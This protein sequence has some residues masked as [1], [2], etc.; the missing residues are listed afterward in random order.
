MRERDI[1]A[2]VCAHARGR[3]WSAIKL[4]GPGDRGKP[5]RIFIAPGGRVKFVEFKAPGK[6]PTALQARWL[7]VLKELGFESHCIDNIDIGRALFD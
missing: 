6:Q 3:G 1:E 4:A 5:D 7:N 2:A